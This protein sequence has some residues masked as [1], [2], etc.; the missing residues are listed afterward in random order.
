M[1]Q[2]AGRAHR[3][4]QHPAREPPTERADE[5][6]APSAMRPRRSLMQLHAPRPLLARLLD[7]V[8]PLGGRSVPPLLT[9]HLTLVR[10][11]MLEAPVVLPHR[12]LLVRRQ[13]LEPVPA[14]AQLAALVRWQGMPALVALLCLSTLLGGHAEPATT[15]AG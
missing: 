10:R 3:R 5:V 2:G 12:G 15:T 13:A 4:L 14:V 11:K 1:V 6:T 7:H 8:L 9:Q